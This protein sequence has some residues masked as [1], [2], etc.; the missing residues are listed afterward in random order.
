MKK[1][2][3]LQSFRSVLDCRLNVTQTLA[4][5]AFLLYLTPAFPHTHSLQL[6]REEGKTIVV[7]THEPDV[8]AQTK[9][10]VVLKDGLIESDTFINQIVLD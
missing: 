8:A 2:F 3:T 9:R 7:V 5:I 4:M 6:V 10:N 1:T